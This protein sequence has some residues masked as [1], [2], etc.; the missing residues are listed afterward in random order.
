M[1]AYY[2]SSC[3]RLKYIEPQGQ[4]A[5]S[6]KNTA[7]LAAAFSV[8]LYARWAH[9]VGGLQW[10]SW[11]VSRRCLAIRSSEVEDATLKLKAALWRKYG[12][13]DGIILSVGSASR[14]NRVLLVQQVEIGGLVMYVDSVEWMA[15]SRDARDAV[16][17]ERRRSPRRRSF[18]RCR[19]RCM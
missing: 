6:L 8:L 12:C 19:R 4:T 9:V 2:A 18:L 7:E 17:P 11:I 1:E 14:S 15:V 5:R 3:P 16:G 10:Q 13:P